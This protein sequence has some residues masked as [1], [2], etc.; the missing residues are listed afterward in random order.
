MATPFFYK[1][2]TELWT[3]AGKA[4]TVAA[5]SAPTK[6]N[7][8]KVIAT[9]SFGVDAGNAVPATSLRGDA[10]TPTRTGV[11]VY[12][13]SLGALT[14][15]LGRYQVKEFLS[16]QLTMH[17]SAASALDV[18]VGVSTPASGKFEAR[19]VNRNTGA[20][21][22]PAAAGADERI[23]WTAVFNVGAL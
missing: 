7:T 22:N 18:E 14:D 1:K 19:V 4:P 16:I 23:S 13:I 21:A 15:V 8:K 11:G 5:G 6:S 12:E 17:K 10:H 20:A 2:L 3:P 9:G